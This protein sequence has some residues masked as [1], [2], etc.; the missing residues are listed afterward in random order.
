MS[1]LFVHLV[2]ARGEILDEVEELGGHVG[3]LLL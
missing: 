1:E 3:D 2:H